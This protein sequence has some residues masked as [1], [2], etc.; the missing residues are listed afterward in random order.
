MSEFAWSVLP[1][2]LQSSGRVKI[3]Q[4]SRP[5]SEWL[6]AASSAIEAHWLVDGPWHGADVTW[7]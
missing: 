7:Y 1:C 5:I 2:K 3:I 4:F 6:F